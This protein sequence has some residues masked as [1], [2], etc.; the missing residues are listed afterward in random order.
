MRPNNNTFRRFPPRVQN[1]ASRVKGRGGPKPGPELRAASDV[2]VMALMARPGAGAV[3]T[4]RE[5]EVG[6]CPAWKK[7]SAHHP[8]EAASA[9]EQAGQWR[10]VQDLGGQVLLLPSAVRLLAQIST[11]LC[12]V[13][14]GRVPEASDWGRAG[15]G[16]HALLHTARGGL[17]TAGRSGMDR[18]WRLAGKRTGAR[19]RWKGARGGHAK[20]TPRPPGGGLAVQLGPNPPGHS[21]GFGT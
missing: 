4:C 15:R 3:S 11:P 18:V 7:W 1:K 6:R 2:D 13:R 9:W 14:L 8:R 16:G 21:Q 12:V 10:I 5:V 20:P 17:G 19:H